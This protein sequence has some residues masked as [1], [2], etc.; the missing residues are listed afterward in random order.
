MCV[1][2]SSTPELQIWDWGA[3][4]YKCRLAC[5]MT[6]CVNTDP[7]LVFM[8]ATLFSFNELRSQARY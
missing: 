6:A 1:R 7:Y 3:F 4:V 2:S 5:G 8:L